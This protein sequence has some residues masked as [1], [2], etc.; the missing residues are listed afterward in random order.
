MATGKRPA[1]E[2]AQNPWIDPV[3]MLVK[4]YASEQL[5]EVVKNFLRDGP[6]TARQRHATG[7]FSVETYVPSRGLPRRAVTRESRA[8]FAH[9]HALIDDGVT[10]G[11]G[12]RVWAF[13][14]IVSGAVLG[15]DCNVCDHTFIEGGVRVGN[16]VTLKCGVFLWDGVTVED[17]VF[18]GPGATLTNDNRPR[19]QRRLKEYPQTVLRRGCTL[20]AHS[21]V[22]PGISIGL[23][24][25]VGAGA[26]VTRD[27]PDY[28]L[29]V[30]NPSRLRAWICE[31]GE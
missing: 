27:V 11:K 7:V 23:Y 26:V 24:A 19:S 15:D 5:L 12:T 14:H 21:T 16:R 10:I 2:L 25:M 20:G 6:V 22:L 28:A 29:V 30:G 8:Y 4:P 3:A 31:C 1:V 18:I 17:D 13:S 9:S